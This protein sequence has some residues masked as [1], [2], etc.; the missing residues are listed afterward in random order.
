MP[1]NGGGD[2]KDLRPLDQSGQVIGSHRGVYEALNVRNPQPGYR[3]LW[4]NRKE[5]FIYKKL[6]QGCK[7]VRS[8]DPEA[9]GFQIEDLPEEFQQGLDSLKPFGDV[10]LMRQSEEDYQKQV[11][12][13][14]E[15]AKAAREGAEAK[16][17]MKGEDRASEVGGADQ[18]RPLYF[19]RKHHGYHIE[20]K[21]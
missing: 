19:A 1:V 7:F 13:Q 4:A 11:S 17:L 6:A 2:R 9:L 3:Y 16:F 10:V 14:Q 15:L 20:E 21:E 12:L 8:G 5:G 18:G